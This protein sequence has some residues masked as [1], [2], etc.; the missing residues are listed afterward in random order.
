MTKESEPIYQKLLNE[1]ISL[2]LEPG[3]RIKEEAV[4]ARF[5]VSR[6][7]IREV[8]K[9]LELEGLL[10]VRPQSGTYVTRIDLSD[11]ADTI[12]IR[13]AVEF[14]VLRSLNNIFTPADASEALRLLD[15]QRISFNEKMRAGE[16]ITDAYF[17]ADNDFHALLYGKANK[18]PVLDRL[19]GENPVFQR[20]RYITFLRSS[21]QLD[22]LYKIH[23]KIVEAVG[24]GD[25]DHLL[26]VVNE[27]NFAGL[28]GLSAVQDNH[29]DWF[30]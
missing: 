6:T 3:A 22:S 17:R 11:I 7:P 28:D 9:K 13:A 2:K 18:K 8:F 30:I 14:A 10:T 16:D 24:R 29:P 26:S 4:S 1:I 21:D 5:G 15:R 23:T 19:N 25:P 20:Y 27:H 12:Y